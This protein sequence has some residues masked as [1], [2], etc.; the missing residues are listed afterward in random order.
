MTV[1]IQCSP[2]LFSYEGQ[3]YHFFSCA[4]NKFVENLLAYGIILK[5][6][7][8]DKITWGFIFKKTFFKKS[9][10]DSLFSGKEG[11]VPLFNWSGED[12]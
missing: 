7:E 9:G 1:L 10:A 6:L 12:C 2:Q 3:I 8:M 4:E 5:H 11:R